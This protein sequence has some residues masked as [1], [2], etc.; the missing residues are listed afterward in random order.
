MS[1]QKHTAEP[2]EVHEGDDYINIHKEGIVIA[3]IYDLEDA[4]R[5]VQCV[6]AMAGIE[7][8]EKFV[9]EVKNILNNM[10]SDDLFKAL[11]PKDATD[12]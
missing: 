12:E 6:K 11:F 9:K 2:W 8:N 4:E 7:D 3:D 5:I 1:E 10:D